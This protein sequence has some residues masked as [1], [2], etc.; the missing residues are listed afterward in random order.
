MGTAANFRIAINKEATHSWGTTIGTTTDGFPQTLVRMA[1]KFNEKAESLNNGHES[2]E[3][4]NF[5]IRIANAVA[6]T[7]RYFF[8]NNSNNTPW[9]SYSALYNPFTGILKVRDEYNKSNYKPVNIGR[10]DL[11]SK[12]D[13]NHEYHTPFHE[14]N[15][16]KR[17]MTIL[18]NFNFFL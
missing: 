11:L 7:D 9:I 17:W 15:D 13:P 14:A 2:F 8:V 5:I 1:K 3:D 16:V 6:A 10:V 18:E 12:V 4:K